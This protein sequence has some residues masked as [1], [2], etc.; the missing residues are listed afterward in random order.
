MIACL[1]RWKCR[2]F[3]LIKCTLIGGA[4]KEHS[5]KAGIHSK[6]FLDNINN[7]MAVVTNTQFYHS[8]LIRRAKINLKFGEVSWFSIEMQITKGSVDRRQMD[9]QA[10]HIG[11]NFFFRN[12]SSACF[13]DGK[14]RRVFHVLFFCCVFYTRQIENYVYFIVFSMDIFRKNCIAVHRWLARFSFPSSPTLLDI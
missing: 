4:R 6:L 3:V 12:S 7:E 9:E 1:L 8:S 14:M 5:K 11:F 13:S 2:V 10:K